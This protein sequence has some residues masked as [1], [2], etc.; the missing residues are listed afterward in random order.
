MCLTPTFNFALPSNFVATALR[1]LA[2]FEL[3]FFQL[4]SLCSIDLF[5]SV[6]LCIVNERQETLKL[7]FNGRITGLVFEFEVKG[8]N[9]SCDVKP[10]KAASVIGKIDCERFLI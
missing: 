7:V 3:P 2:S 6:H 10:R 8:D 4:I 9:I 5:S 1:V